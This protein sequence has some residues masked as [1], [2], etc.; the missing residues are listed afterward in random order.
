M[1]LKPIASSTH[2]LMTLPQALWLSV[3]PLQAMFSFTCF[4]G[5]LAGP[6]GYQPI[7]YMLIHFV[8]ETPH[9]DTSIWPRMLRTR[10]LFLQKKKE[11]NKMTNA[12]QFELQNMFC[13]CKAYIIKQKRNAF[14]KK[15]I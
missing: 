8:R 5:Q 11:Y 1:R 7:H 9:L 15:I 12:T 6:C 14:I 2:N 13:T 3:L 4:V 10:T